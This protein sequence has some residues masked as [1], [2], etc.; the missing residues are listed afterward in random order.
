MILIR[1]K[2]VRLDN[3]SSITTKET[4]RREFPR[5]LKEMREQEEFYA[6]ISNVGRHGKRVGSISVDFKIHPRRTR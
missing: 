2:R 5:L 1:F 6:A 3:L 4:T